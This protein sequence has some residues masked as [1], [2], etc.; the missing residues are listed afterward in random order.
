MVFK[1]VIKVECLQGRGGI[2]YTC[3]ERLY[4]KTKKK[5]VPL[6]TGSTF[7]DGSH[8]TTFKSTGCI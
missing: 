3:A 2:A 4:N 8:V 1:E 7:F 6:D 5:G